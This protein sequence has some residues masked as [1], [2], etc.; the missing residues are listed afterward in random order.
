LIKILPF[1]IIPMNNL[2][3]EDVSIF[4][5]KILGLKS[6]FLNTSRNNNEQAK[7]LI[8]QMRELHGCAV[9]C[10]YRLSG[11]INGSSNDEDWILLSTNCSFLHVMHTHIRVC[12]KKLYPST[13]SNRGKSESI[14]LT[15]P[16][17]PTKR[18]R[19]TQTK[20]VSLRE[21][22]TDNYSIPNNKSDM[23]SLPNRADTVKIKI[24]MAG[25]YGDE[26]DYDEDDES[27]ETDSSDMD[28]EGGNYSP[29]YRII[30][31]INTENYDEIMAKFIGGS[32]LDE[33][34]KTAIYI[35]ADWCPHCQTKK[36]F[37]EEAV[38]DTRASGVQMID[39]NIA[40]SDINKQ[41]ATSLDV[42][43]IPTL[44]IFNPT[45]K[46]IS[47]VTFESTNEIIQAIQN[48]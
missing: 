4:C 38:K 34:K 46:K 3:N 30:N 9:W 18:V 17:P 16:T 44:A 23:F 40:D 8:K 37:W 42:T 22:P 41:I 19:P 48:N 20:E 26:D 45:T 31:A 2:R 25:G 39:I 7:H 24:D 29:T 1:N 47:K 32:S 35:W 6:A 10:Q 14:T 13:E 5:D 11:R 12:E 15:T 43:K 28:M 27:Y 21:V 33:N 36:P